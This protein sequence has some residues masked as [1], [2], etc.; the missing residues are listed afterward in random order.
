MPDK[1]FSTVGSG[2]A[3][4][5]CFLAIDNFFLQRRRHLLPGSALQKCF[6]VW[7]LAPTTGNDRAPSFTVEAVARDVRERS[8]GV[9]SQYTGKYLD[10]KKSRRID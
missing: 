7:L 3:P 9:R 8:N 5:S 4:F 2:L 6:G 1:A 10:L